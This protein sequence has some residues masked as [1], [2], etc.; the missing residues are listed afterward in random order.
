MAIVGEDTP[1][2]IYDDELSEPFLALIEGEE[3]TRGARRDAPADPAPDAEPD[4]RA[5]PA[6]AEPETMDQ[7]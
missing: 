5:D 6:V 2:K 4:A 7:S 1:L 3:R